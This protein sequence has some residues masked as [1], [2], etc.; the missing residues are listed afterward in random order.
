MLH[1]PTPQP[2]SK[3]RLVLNCMP[4]EL[5]DRLTAAAVDCRVRGKR[6]LSKAETADKHLRPDV[7][8]ERWSK[9]QR[10]F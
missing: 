7:T 10:Y 8:S 5:A 1:A 6:R 4:F 3:G 2:P 9:G